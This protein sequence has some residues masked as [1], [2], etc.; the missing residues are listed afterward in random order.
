MEGWME[1]VRCGF[2]EW[3]VEWVGGLVG[4]LVVARAGRAKAG[5]DFRCVRHG[6]KWV[7]RRHAQSRVDR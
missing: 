2:V 5:S 7:G 1:S 3:F 6:W 4:C